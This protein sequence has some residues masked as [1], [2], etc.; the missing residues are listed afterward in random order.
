MAVRNIASVYRYKFADCEINL[1]E[2]SLIP[3]STIAISNVGKK[4]SAQ[5]TV[6]H[7]FA[8][9]EENRFR[10]VSLKKLLKMP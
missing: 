3:V 7:V 5:D 4:K 8:A 2:S 9:L 6:L 1:R 10:R